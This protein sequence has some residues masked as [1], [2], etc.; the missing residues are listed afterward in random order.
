MNETI[1]YSANN[2]ET[3]CNM[4]RGYNG[5]GTKEEQKENFAIAN[6]VESEFYNHYDRTK[7]TPQRGDVVVFSDGFQIYER[8]NVESCDQYGMLYLCENGSTFTDGRC[9]STSGGSFTHLHASHFVFV[10]YTESHLT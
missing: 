6:Q 5:V 7:K 4:N 3:F 2:F 10:G 8:G 9:F 1:N